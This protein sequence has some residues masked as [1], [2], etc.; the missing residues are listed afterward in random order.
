MKTLSWE[1]IRS[2]STYCAPACGR[3]CTFKEHATAMIK[4]KRLAGR[5]GKGW[6]PFVHENLGWHYRAVR[7][8]C[9]VHENGPRHYWANLNF[10]GRQF[11]A[12]ATTPKAAIKKALTEAKELL[13]FVADDIEEFEK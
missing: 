6:S 5:L 3:G 1:P 12:T 7:E 2:G 13:S 9:A 11:H 4:A 8:E 10:G